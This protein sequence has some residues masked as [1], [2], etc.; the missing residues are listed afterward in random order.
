[1][2]KV[3]LINH[4]Y[5]Y[6]VFQIISLFYNKSE[7]EFV[8]AEEEIVIAAAA[9]GVATAGAIAAATT[10]ETAKASVAAKAAA[11]ASASRSTSANANTNRDSNDT[12]IVMQLESGYDSVNSKVYCKIT[13]VFEEPI[14][15]EINSNNNSSNK[16]HFKN[17]I[18]LT[19][20]NC[21]KQLTGMDIPW[22]IL[23]GIRPTKIVHEAIKTGQDLKS[24][25]DKLTIDFQ[26]SEEKADLTLEVANN[27]AE[28]LKC[29]EKDIGIYIGIPFCPT[30]C[31]YCSF[32]SNSIMGKEE[33]VEEYINAL[34]SE[35]EQMLIYLN[36][37]G[38]KIDTLYFG[39]GTPTA[40]SVR[41][42]DKI[43]N[44]IGKYIN[45][46]GLREFTIEAGR[47]D[48]I[49]REKLKVIKDSGCSRISI[50]PQT[51]NDETLRRIGRMHSSKE[52]IDKFY[53]AR[54][55]G[56][57]NINMDMILG[58]PGEGLVEIENTLKILGELSPEN[59]TVHT[60]AIKRASVLNQLEYRDNGSKA[61]LMHKTTENYLR[62][63]DMY[64]YYMYRQKNMISPLE[65]VGYCIKDHECVYNIQMISENIPVI[66][67]GADAVTKAVFKKEN[68]IE[69]SANVK[70]VREY[71]NRVDEMVNN[72]I[73]IFEAR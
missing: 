32:T 43:I 19:I 70:D 45:L 41:G 6:E 36:S 16:K 59:I 12:A 28:F 15:Y 48:S 72:K 14:F 2:F 37:K 58:L 27:E 4:E 57:N 18:K 39:G 33:L 47:A 69:R 24:I 67:F 10:T 11:S 56:F 21:L 68:R 61:A 23:I 8:Q 50:N 62:K 3:K 30:R 38:Y 20:L 51:M 31:S 71:I 22:G 52:V 9:A 29:S 64:P 55:L 40:L 54:E 63:M 26:V 1:M 42:L 44:S 73:S 46:K 66:A 65:N 25:R 34:I 13:G 53:L 35:S 49:D 60:L 17:A 5:R 7:F